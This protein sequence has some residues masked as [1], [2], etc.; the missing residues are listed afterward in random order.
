M[1]RRPARPIIINF[2]FSEEEYDRLKKIADHYGL[3][4]SATVRMLM[5]K[6]E[7]AIANMAAKRHPDGPD[8][9]VA[10][11]GLAVPVV[12]AVLPAASRAPGARSKGGT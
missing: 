8:K 1:D 5:K 12:P 7:R 10:T 9:E 11:S 4:A 6:Q 3:D 2:R